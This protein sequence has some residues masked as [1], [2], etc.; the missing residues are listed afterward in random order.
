[1]LAKKEESN[2]YYPEQIELEVDPLERKAK[3]S[4][5]SIKKKK[6]QARSK[7]ITMGLAI[8]GL[9]LSLVVLLGYTNITKMRTE[10]TALETTNAE[11]AREEEDIL[12]EMEIL[13]SSLNIEENAIIKLGMAY[14]MKDQI[15]NVN[16]GDIDID[17]I[18]DIENEAT[19]VSKLKGIVNKVSNL[20]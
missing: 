16:V 14:P 8:L 11:L 15:V 9:V 19:F 5:R 13:K 4:N 7:L 1:M 12:S 6:S 17:E 3:K 18:R 2:Y 20:F 10:I